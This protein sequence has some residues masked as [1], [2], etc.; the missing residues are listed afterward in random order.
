MSALTVFWSL[1]SYK[2]A[3]LATPGIAGAAI[4]PVYFWSSMV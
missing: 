3:G 1:S 4:A 2:A